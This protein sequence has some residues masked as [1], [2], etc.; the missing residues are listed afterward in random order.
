MKIKNALLV[1][2]SL[3]A[4]TLGVLLFVSCYGHYF[5]EDVEDFIVYGFFISFIV[6]VAYSFITG[7]FALV[8]SLNNPDKIDIKY[9][10]LTS[11]SECLIKSQF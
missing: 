4:A 8:A 2:M 9:S 10:L 5:S 7:I 6:M 1:I 3:F 11:M